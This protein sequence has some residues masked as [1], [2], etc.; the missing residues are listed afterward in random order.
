MT[1]SIK[2]KQEQK[3]QQAYRL[4][5]AGQKDAA[6]QL[7]DELSEESV[8]D[9]KLDGALAYLYGRLGY[10]V[11]AIALYHKALQLKPDDPILLAGL[12][13]AYSATR[14]YPEAHAV[15]SRALDID[16]RCI[17][18]VAEK[19]QLLLA[20]QCYTEG[21][22]WLKKAVELNSNDTSIYTN[23]PLVLGVLG[24][25]EEAME[26][27]ERAMRRFPKNPNVLYAVGRTYVAGGQMKEA[28]S[29][30][31]KAIRIEPSYGAVYRQLTVSKRFT[32][33]DLSIV[34]QAEA[35]L[36]KGGMTSTNKADFL[37]ALGKMHDDLGNC[38]KAFSFYLQA[39]SLVK[40]S[41][42]PDD[43]SQLRRFQKKLLS[44]V[45]NTRGLS[46]GDN[47]DIPVFVMGMP[48]SGTTLVEQIVASHPKA[49]G[50]GELVEIHKIADSIYQAATKKNFFGITRFSM[51]E[52]AV[53]K[54]FSKQYLSVLCTEREGFVRITDKMPGNY[55]F[56]GL[57]SIM[58]PQARMLHVIR[59]PLDVCLSCYFQSFLGQA[60]SNDLQWIAE[61]YRDYRRTMDLWKKLLPS[62][63]IVD[64]YY[65]QLIADPEPESRRLIAACGLEWDPACLDFQ[66]RKA[67]VQTASVWQVR[68][69]IYQS[70]KMRWIPYAR[71]LTGLAS[72]ISEF[73][74][75]DDFR[76]FEEKGLKVK[77]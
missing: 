39:N 52:E 37:F 6:R 18:A 26:Y 15:L 35:Q 29:M 54:E 49:A 2:K 3:I 24:H 1:S 60:W 51:P 46:I 28:E 76:I 20:T 58:F 73:L 65:E 44:E 8:D 50:A 47:T 38:D 4:A 34:E 61:T 41:V 19:A 75:E 17:E 68:Q 27:A 33:D 42:K 30:L 70:S 21:V 62:G 72:E 59:H 66:N 9:A 13:K 57:I 31:L 43:G 14:Q 23:L 40:A 22:Q 45:H 10:F 77:R 48:R 55:R 25:H 53:W 5:E 12:A 16:N 64:I 74:T 63:K 32:M 11:S 7:A 69:P 36:G 56:L 67:A 71:H